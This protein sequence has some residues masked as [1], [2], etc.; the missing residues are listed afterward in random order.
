[1]NIID[2]FGTLREISYLCSMKSLKFIIVLSAAAVIMACGGKNDRQ[3]A[4][5]LLQQA[6]TLFQ[7]QKYEA[8]LTSLDSLRS[9]YHDQIEARKQGI[10]LR[11][12][13]ELKKAQNELAVVDSALLATTKYYN[14]I[15]AIA[16]KAKNA[17]IATAKQLD[18]VTMQRMKRDSLQVKFDIL[19][20]QIR[21]IHQKQREN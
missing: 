11:Q 7:Q 3:A 4:D 10:K 16:E 17:G 21:Y 6:K 9:K 5:E 18:E 2:L 14:D 12:D 20:G 15:K 8:A 1:M 13:I 19:G